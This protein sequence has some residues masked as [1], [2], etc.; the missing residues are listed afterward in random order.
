MNWRAFFLFAEEKL[1]YGILILLL[2]CLVNGG[3]A[4]V[5]QTISYQGVLADA[6]G[7]AV[8]DGDYDLTFTLYD[9]ASG[10]TALWTE[11]QSVAVVGG[12]F[13]VAL[14]SVTPFDLPFDAPYWLGSQ[15]GTDG[16]L[17]PRIELTASPYSLN[18]A[19]V[20]DS[21][22][23]GATIANAVAVRSLNGLTDDVTLT[24]E[25][26]AT[27][28]SDGNRIVINAGSGTGTSAWS[29]TGNAGTTPETNFLGTT[30]D[31]PLEVKVNGGRAFRFEP[32]SEAP[33]I[34]GGWQENEISSG[35][36][37]V[38]AGGGSPGG[39]NVIT[40]EFAFIGG[41]LSNKAGG[42]AAVVVGGQLN[43]ALGAYSMAPGGLNCLAGS[44]FSFA[45][46]NG[47]KVRT[48]EDAEDTDGDKGTFVWADSRFEDFE[49][50]G[51]DQF[52]IRA[53]GGVGIGTNAPS[54]PLTV[55]GEIESTEGGFKFP[56]GTVQVSAATGGG[57]AWSLT[58]NAGLSSSNF[59]GT[60]DNVPLEI[61][62][63]NTRVMRYE[64]E[65]AD[66]G[67][68]VVGGWSGNSVAEGVFGATINGGGDPSSFGSPRPNQ[69]TANYG[70]IG[71]GRGNK[72]SESDATVGGG[73]G[74]TAS[75]IAAVISGG[76]SNTASGSHAAIGGG[77]DNIASRATA[78]VAGGELNQAEGSWA[79]VPGGRSNHA[80]A[81]FSFAAGVGAR[82]IHQGSFVWNDASVINDSLVST[83]ENQFLIRAAGGVGIGTNA[84]S[85]PLTV[86]GVIESIEGGFKFPD[87][88]IQTTAA[89]TGS[90]WLLDGNSGIT[91]N[92]FLGT[93]DE[94]ALVFRV[95]NLRAF[96][97]EPEENS[98][99]EP[100]SPSIIGGSDHNVVADGV[101]GA[102]ISGGGS[103]GFTNDVNAR[104][105]TI[106]GGGGNKVNEEYGTISGG[107]GNEAG[108]AYSSV[109]GGTVNDALGRYSAILG[110][111]RN[112]ARA[113]LSFGL[114]QFTRAN[115]EGTFLF[116]DATTT[117]NDSLS[118]TAPNQFLIRATGGVG[119]GTNTPQ[120][121]L[122]VTEAIDGSATPTGHV[123]IIENNAGSTSNGPD[124]L[125]LKTSATTPGG[126]TNFITFFDG[127]DQGVGRIE[128]N[129][130]GGVQYL[131][132]GA[133]YAEALPR[134]HPEERIEKG[135]V[136]GVFSGKITRRTAT[137][138]HLMVVSSRPAVL[139]NMPPEN[140]AS[141]FE[142]VAFLGQVNV[143]VRGPVRSG[144][145]IVAT[146]D[147][148]GV[149]V[150]ISSTA[151]TP[152]HLP[153]IVA[154]A[155]ESS[156]D[157]GV[158]L[159]NA[160][161]G[162]PAYEALARIRHKGCFPETQLGN[163]QEGE[164]QA[165]GFHFASTQESIQRPPRAEDDLSI[166]KLL[167]LVSEQKRRIAIQQ[168][169]IDQLQDSVKKLTAL[170]SQS[171][172]EVEQ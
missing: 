147:N 62:V 68:N 38:I 158:K 110:G 146:G 119:I 131:T 155:W 92:Q 16:A 12:V 122:H 19:S 69:V 127:N 5:P 83:A 144:D 91:N 103:R 126:N 67:P 121:Q 117:F 136:V 14:G 129:G 7:N 87:G 94:Q 57:N 98:I 111:H 55:V 124:V 159:V 151:L 170:H 75:G 133:D 156:D 164:N 78:T 102:T 80:R 95:N 93:R 9:A 25:G 118:S 137:A 26:G 71:G 32:T 149:G 60:T 44:D 52:L 59:I 108:G 2:F 141:Q 27:I 132:T 148:D 53:G 65:S 48:P 89:G 33:N 61:R 84:P 70:A 168:K 138:E 120:A 28:T 97:I 157:H 64:P 86:A 4:Q 10:G 139:G 171:K 125:A 114:G 6:D 56:D 99:G 165:A 172:E 31:Q 34:V 161:V 105:G 66:D 63:S 150:A 142:K 167:D 58:G 109:A 17:Q 128:G 166:T 46:G 36:A 130:A 74:N 82:A 104:Y 18:A 51:P 30:D 23:T 107:S 143:K 35:V 115:H 1:S 49:S 154:R 73:S 11:T 29:L 163:G 41:G 13:N 85:S 24:A 160:L 8:P 37:S 76:Q 152:E 54:S 79:T 90:S 50:T 169:Q 100:D 112:V 140:M 153:H 72:A 42:T 40:E 145:V 22:V 77:L 88:T 39:P 20:A 134:L 135:D 96:R 106:G 162:L 43:R 116:G 81:S 113:E 47:A 123:A 21:S 45:G 3:V 101:A 15:I